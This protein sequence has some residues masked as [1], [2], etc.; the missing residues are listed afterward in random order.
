M[1][2]KLA[3]FDMDGTVFESYLNWKEIKQ[4]LNLTNK[5]ILKEIYKKSP[6]D[7]KK[8]QI[9]E[10][11]EEE[12]TKKTKPIPGISQFITFLKSRNINTG[13]TTNNNKNITEFLLEKYNLRFDTV[14]T[15]EM[16]LWK[17]DPDPFIHLMRLYNC[18]PEE[19][20]SIGDSHY[21][22]QAA[23]KSHIPNIFIKKS[24]RIMEFIQDN[25]VLFEDYFELKTIIQK[26]LEINYSQPR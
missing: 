8:L 19:T 21:D 6:P 7:Y 22:I 18:H 1:A 13:L 9:L 24:E 11:Y 14:I 4:E 16:N 23:I 10:K 2:L 17:P 12:N 26:Q 5:N 15:R 20:L 3:V 25:M